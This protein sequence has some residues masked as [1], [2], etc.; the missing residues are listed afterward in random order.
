MKNYC[1]YFLYAG[2]LLLA[3]STLG[4]FAHAE[5]ADKGPEVNSRDSALWC[6]WSAE[7]RQ[8]Y[9]KM[10]RVILAHVKPVDG[11]MQF[12]LTKEEFD[13]MGLPDTMYMRLIT[14][15]KGVNQWMDSSNMPMAKREEM[16]TDYL[17]SM[18]QFVL[19]F[20]AFCKSKGFSVE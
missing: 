16:T 17:E 19:N 6:G 1:S 3:M 13:R 20:N 12:D 2:T 11:S 10:G 9:A 4:G 15:L 5:V 14:D 18:K 8:A 7:Q